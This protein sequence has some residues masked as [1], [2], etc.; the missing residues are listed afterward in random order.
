MPDGEYL[1]DKVNIDV[2]N[3][4]EVSTSGLANYLRQSPNHKVLGFWKLQ[5]GVYNLSGKNPDGRFNKWVRKM[6]QEPVIYDP[7][8]TDQSARQLR[9]A[10][11]N[12]CSGGGRHHCDRQEKDDGQLPALSRHSAHGV[13]LFG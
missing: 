9:L 12:R 3:S 2:V 10:L 7:Q 1:L 6:G 4:P 13:I 5:L 11:L 8:L